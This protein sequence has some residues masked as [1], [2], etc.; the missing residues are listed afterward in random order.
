[1]VFTC[2]ELV[3]PVWAWW[4]ELIQMIRHESNVFGRER[5]QDNSDEML[6]GISKERFIARIKNPPSNIQFTGVITSIA[7]KAFEIGMVEAVVT[8]HRSK[9]DYFFPEPVLALSTEEILASGGSKPVL[10]STLVSLEKAYQQGIKRLLVI[11][12]SCHVQ[13]LREFKRRFP[14]LKDMDIYVVGPVI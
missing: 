9:E 12:A 4:I 10:A 13:N 2:M 6:F 7:K 14:Y 3:F 11:G 5:S 1:M 8:L